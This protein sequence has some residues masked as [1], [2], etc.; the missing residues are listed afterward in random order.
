VTTSVAGDMLAGFFG[1]SAAAGFTA[2]ATMS[3]RFDVVSSAGTYR[4]ASE[5]TDEWR[6]AAGS[7]GSRSAT[8]SL[9]AAAVGQLVALRPGSGGPPPPPP[10]PPPPGNTAPTANAGSAT[11]TKGT[12][13][14]ATLRG[15]DA[16]ASNCELTFTIATQPAHG[17]LGA[18]TNQACQASSPNNDTA[19]VSYT[20]AAGYTGADSFSFQVSDGTASATAVISI[21][22]ND[23]PPPPGSLAF[24]GASSAG[25]ATAT[26]LTIP[27]PAGAQSG[28]VEL[29]SV[30]VRGSP[31]ITAPVG[32]TLVRS[33]QSGF[34]IKQAVYWHLVGSSEPADYTWTW[35]PA[36]GASGG[37]AA[38]GGVNTTTPIDASS[39]QTGS[40]TAITA[41]TVTTTVAGTML[42]GFFGTSAPATATPP[43]GMSERFDVFSS[44]GT[45]RAASEG[46]DQTLSAAG[47]SGSRTATASLSAANIGQL[48]ALKPA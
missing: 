2:P 31:A 26:S 34:T 6:S 25:N 13:V 12:A 17:T 5:G 48:V 27:A 37:I 3:E 15:S 41:P 4:T 38:Y 7:T 11:T 1:T 29:A 18:I 45:Y 28:D 32:W 8:A 42:V 22:I 24:H 10:P 46:A 36:Q 16:D 20:P 43:S 14:T 39:G 40:G 47:A 33:D 9:S 21:T 19:T 23:T 35:S 30:T 44:A